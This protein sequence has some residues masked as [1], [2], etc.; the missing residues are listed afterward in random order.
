[1]IFRTRNF[2]FSNIAKHTF[3][4]HILIQL[5]FQVLRPGARRV[6]RE[7]GPGGHTPLLRLQPLQGAG[8]ETR[9]QGQLGEGQG[10]IYVWIPWVEFSLD[11]AT[12]KFFPLMPSGTLC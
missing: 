12:L 7:Q 9:R 2:Y 10:R 11:L 1:M 6:L 4:Q 5:S 8:Q 3:K